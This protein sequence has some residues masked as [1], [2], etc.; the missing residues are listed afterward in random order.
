MRAP[1]EHAIARRAFIDV[2]SGQAASGAGRGGGMV[3]ISCEVVYGERGTESVC[4]CT[5]MGEYVCMYVERERARERARARE[6]ERERAR[7][8]ADVRWYVCEQ[9]LGSAWVINVSCMRTSEHERLVGERRRCMYKKYTTH[10]KRTHK[11]S[12]FPQSFANRMLN[13]EC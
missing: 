9:I 10:H 12:S 5:D 13:V 1:V 8:R 11:Y 6:R 3:M 2:E 7:A 4:L